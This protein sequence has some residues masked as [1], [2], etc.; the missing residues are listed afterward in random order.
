MAGIKKLVPNKWSKAIMIA[1]T[2]SA[3]NANNPRMV[4]TKIPHTERGILIKVM[5][6]V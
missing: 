4:A 3:G 1:D 2:N 5:P 6:W